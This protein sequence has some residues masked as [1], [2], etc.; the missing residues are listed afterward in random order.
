MRSI[1]L[2]L[3]ML[4]HLPSK[5]SPMKI[6]KEI[7]SPAEHMELTSSHRAKWFT[8]SDDMLSVSDEIE[9][10]ST[11]YGPP[12]QIPFKTVDKGATYSVDLK[13]VGPVFC[14]TI[15]KISDGIGKIKLKDELYF[16]DDMIGNTFS[17][18]AFQFLISC[19]RADLSTRRGDEMGSLYPPLSTA[20][21]KNTFPV[22]SDFYFPV[23]LWNIF[24]EVPE[25]N[26]GL[27]LLLQVD[28]LLNKIIK[29]IPN[30]PPDKEAHVRSLFKE[31]VQNNDHAYYDLFAILHS[32]ENWW[33]EEIES[34]I[35]KYVLSLKLNRGQGYMVNDRK[36]LHGRGFTADEVTIKRL[37]R[38]LF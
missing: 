26:Q 35:D 19:I 21:P 22:H 10:E 33:A 28:T 30:F 20:K 31:K 1:N 36:W 11:K 8:W 6:F 34:G 15:L 14:K 23:H 16:F 18:E 38:L 7:Q 24:D 2:V 5:T 17:S 13:R 27:S 4:I 37:H 9:A 29:Q 32:K 25:G 12:D 3:G